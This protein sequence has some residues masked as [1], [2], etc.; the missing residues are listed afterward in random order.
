MFYIISHGIDGYEELINFNEIVFVRSAY[1]FT[2]E[3][4]TYTVEIILKNGIKEKI[5]LSEKGYEWFKKQLKVKEEI[6]KDETVF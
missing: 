4:T 3:I 6:K 2:N 1:N 5:Y